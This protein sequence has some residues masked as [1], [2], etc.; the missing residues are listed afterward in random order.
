MRSS[1]MFVCFDC[2]ASVS[3]WGRPRAGPAFSRSFTLT[4]T[5]SCSSSERLSHHS[6]KV[7]VYSTSHAMDEICH[8]VHMMS[9]EKSRLRSSANEP[10]TKL[11]GENEQSGFHQGAR[12]RV[13]ARHGRKDGD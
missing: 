10:I 7:S 2:F 11:P 13:S 9:S 4:A 5:S 1:F 6:A 8:R 3:T 12:V